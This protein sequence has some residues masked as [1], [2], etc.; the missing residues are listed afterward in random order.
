VLVCA[1]S[2][3][4]EQCT[5]LSPPNP[6]SIQ[7]VQHQIS[8]TLISNPF[9]ATPGDNSTRC[10]FHDLPSVVAGLHLAFQN[11]HLRP[12]P[13]AFGTI[14]LLIRCLPGELQCFRS[15]LDIPLT[16]TEAL[17]FDIGEATSCGLQFGAK[18]G[19]VGGSCIPLVDTG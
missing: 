5:Q 16:D 6:L 18:C 1:F 3:S 2:S 7:R 19:R 9:D 17:D 13:S 14:W 10:P 4:L 8:Q 15:Q 12:E 11:G